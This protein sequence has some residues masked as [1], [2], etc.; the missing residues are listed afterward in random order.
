MDFTIFPPSTIFKNVHVEK[1]DPS[2]A[3]IDLNVEELIVSFTYSSFIASDLEIDDLNLKNGALKIATFDSDTPDFNWKDLDFKK[4]YGVYSNILASS[5]LHLNIARLSNINVQVNNSN[6]LIDSL[7]I[8]PHRKDVLF[9]AQASQ[10]HIE[11]KIKNLSVIEIDRG[12]AFIH[13]TRDQWKIEALHLEKN[14]NKIDFDAILFNKQKTI[15]AN[16]NTSFDLNIESLLPMYS[17]LPPEF[18]N[19]KGDVSGTLVTSGD[20]LDPDA[21]MAFEAK[22]FKSQWI[23]LGNVKANLKKKKNLI[24]LERF[25]AQNM[26]E[27]YE[28]LKSQTFYDLKKKTLFHLRIP[29][30]L[31]DA[32][33][34]TFLYSIKKVL[35]N[36]KGY[37]TGKVEVIWDG[38]K[39]FFEMKEKVLLKNFKLLSDAKKPILQNA[40]FNLEDT[41]ISLDQNLK[42]GINAKLTMNNSLIKA[43]GEITK[44]DINISIKESRLDMKSFGPIAGLSLSGAGPVSAEIYGPFDNVK[45]DFI[46]DWNNFSLLDLNFGKV[47]SEFSLGLKDLQIDINT[48]SGAFNQTLFTADGMLN[49]GEKNPGMD[50]KLDFKNSNFNDAKKMYD[51]IFKNLKLPL[52]PEFNFSAN[53]RVRGGY[54]VESLKIDGKILGSDLKIANEQAERLSLDFSLEKNTLSFKNVR[55]NKS[56]GEI[57]G[58]V[59][60]NLANNYIEH[61]G[62]VQGLRL[63][64]FNF[65]QKLNMEY[66]GDLIVDFDGNGTKDNF[67]SRFKTKV[68]N[69]FIENIPASPSSALIYLNGDEVVVNANLL[70]GKVK[71]DS[72]IN[73]KSRQVSV[74][75]SI[76]TTDIRELLG[77]FARHNMSEKTISGK[78]KAQLNSQFNM[79]TLVMSKF[80]LDFAQFN[81]KKGDINLSVDPRHNFVEID[82]GIVKN[83]DLRFL[84]KL[85]FFRSTAKNLPNGSIVCDQHFSLKTG[86]LELATNSIDK[87]VGLIRGSNQLIIDKKIHI[88]KFELSGTKNSLKIRNLPGAITDLEYAI[89][90]KG[91]SFEIVRFQGNY[92]EGGFKASGAFIFDDIYPQVNIDY[93]IERSTVPLFKR[94]SILLSSNG[95]ITGTDLPYKLNGKVSLLYGEFLDDPSDFTKENKINL[96]PFKKYLPQKSSAEKKG[97][98]NLNVSFDTVNPILIKNNLAEVYVKASG[99]LEGDV[100]DPQIN[101]RV[102][103]IPSVSKFKFKGHD[104]LLNQGYVEIRDHEKVRFSD[105]KFVGLA[106]I[107]DYD[108]KLDISGPIEKSA[109]NLSSEPPLAQEDLVSLLTLGVTSDMSKNLEASDRK[110][111]TT[112]GIGTLLVDQLKINEDLNSTLGL[113]L[114]VLPEFKEDETSLVSGKSAVS[115][116]GT[117]KLKTATKI[118][119]KKQINKI[120][121]VSVSSTVG[122]SIEQTQ[123]MNVNVNIN[124]NFSL[125]GI[126]EVTPSEDVNTTNTPNSVGLDIKYR[127]SF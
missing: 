113:N 124:K 71:L 3:D 76:A 17:D 78:V 43:N 54:S 11:H 8:A 59:T 16:G 104:F 100:L 9:K 19:L 118:K 93:K 28:L 1:N 62:S 32:Y 7:S 110:S 63:S 46:I 18:K 30:Y 85:D 97:Y 22:Q 14:K 96:D 119:V 114:S 109:I 61:E 5:P 38:E 84:D 33:T 27:Q 68:I 99:Q 21:E 37:L 115:D 34:N 40:G 39:V 94:S 23:E 82:N 50:V 60:I 105:I 123:E 12:E 25:F 102:D 48:L 79:D 58:G 107:N 45:F 111:V 49:F 77:I 66:D 65:Y 36:L 44:K 83:W 53:Y 121:D 2:F 52:N 69:P 125:E 26:S 120:V 81:I 29:L 106:K 13:L 95:T 41:R 88:S 122:G 15:H 75:S 90:K 112:V 55:I 24:S 103:A 87:A 108:V 80:L 20:L 42:V 35:E 116:T 47:K 89:S 51:L 73:F 127:R 117:S 91:D 56:R 10:L 67:S 31:R 70:S 57:N 64:D 74:K 86:L 98:L 4:L 72:S 92:G 101:G 6:F 126:Y